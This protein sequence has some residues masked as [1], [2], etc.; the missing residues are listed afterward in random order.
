MCAERTIYTWVTVWRR[1]GSFKQQHG[2]TTRNRFKLS[3]KAQLMVREEL[4]RN[5]Q[6]TWEQ[7]SH[8]IWVKTGETVSEYVHHVVACGGALAGPMHVLCVCQIYAARQMRN[9]C[10]HKTSTRHRW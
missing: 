4:D 7:L 1:T 9:V 8:L 10:Y 5:G 2:N 6:Q 3:E